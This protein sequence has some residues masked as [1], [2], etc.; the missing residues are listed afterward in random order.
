M[1]NLDMYYVYILKSS[2]DKLY[3]GSTSD[4]KRRMREHKSK[5]VFSTKNGTWSLIYY[6]AFIVEEDA[7]NREV[8]LKKHGQ[9]KAQLKKRLKKCLLTKVS[10]G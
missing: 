8:Q 7:R 1:Y 4:L 10:A 2:E 6:E 9:A 3:Y 5:H